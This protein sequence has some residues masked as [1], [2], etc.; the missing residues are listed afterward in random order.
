MS[1][2]EAQKEQ[3]VHLAAEEVSFVTLADFRLFPDDCINL[4][5]P[6]PDVGKIFQGTIPC[7]II[8]RYRRLASL[9]NDKLASHAMESVC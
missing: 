8:K 5:Q 3:P 1:F 6:Y 4:L 2:G 7:M 9:R